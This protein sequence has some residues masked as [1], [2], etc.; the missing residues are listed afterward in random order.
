MSKEDTVEKL[1][2]QGF[3]ANLESGV[4]MVT[5]KSD[6]ERNRVRRKIKE[7]GIRGSWGMRGSTVKNDN[8]DGYSAENEQKASSTQ[9][10]IFH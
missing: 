6:A 5:V 8:T 7:L 3:S 2:T 1:K 4:V 9:R 10:A